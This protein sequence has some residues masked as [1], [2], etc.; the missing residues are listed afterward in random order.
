M[1]K[2]EVVVTSI[3]DMASE[4]MESTGDLIIFDT[5]PLDGLEEISIMHT[6]GE[7]KRPIQVGDRVTLGKT[8]YT[9]TAIGDEA[10]KTLE[11]LG[12]CTFKFTGS[13]T[14]ELPGQIELRGEGHPEI[15]LH[16]IIR[17]EGN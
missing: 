12:H 6:T 13:D 14:V 15:S 9:I 16:D 11:E 5:C 4:L 7:I 17:I 10:L 1:M 2:Y 3:G 8:Q